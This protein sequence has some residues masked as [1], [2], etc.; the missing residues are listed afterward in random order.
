M[1]RYL[2]IHAHFYQPPRENPWLEAVELQE[3]AY[4]YHDWNER[5]TAECYA[6]NAASRILTGD[7][8]ITRIVNNYSRIS[9]NFGPTLL[10]WMADHSPDVYEAIL[11]ADRESRERFSQHGSALAQVYNHM[12]LPLANRRDKETQVIWGLRDF[13]YRFG[14]APEGM[15]LAETAVDVE[16]LEVLAANGI[17]FTV[18]AP[19]QARHERRIA[20]TK[21]KNVEGGNIDPTRAY[22][23]PLPSGR[24]INL[25]FYDG[26]ISRAV[27]F[28]GLLS[29][30]FRFANRLLSGFADHRRFPQLMHIATD[31]ETYGHHHPKG[32][33]ALSYALHH[34]ESGNLAKLTNYGEFLE[35]V[36]PTH[37]VEIID[38]TA[39]SCVHGLGRWTRDCGCNSG[40]KP[41]WNQAWR[42]PLRTALDQLRDSLAAPYEKMAA[43]LLRDPWKARDEYIDVVLNRGQRTLKSFLDQHALHELTDE[44]IVTALSL[45]E[46]QRHAMLMY[47]SC[48]WFFD[49]LSGIETVQV[50]MYAGRA[51]QLAQALFPGNYEEAFRQNLAEAKS[52]LPDH[53]DGARVYD[54][55]VKPAQVDLLA[56]AAHYA[57]ASLFR[58]ESEPSMISSYEIT[59]RDDVRMESGRARL[60]VGT[61][62]IRS[63]ITRQQTEVS[64]GVLH[65]GDHN[66]SA[67]VRA[68]Q[69]EPDFR[70]RVRE[71]RDA[72]NAADLPG[73]LR[74]LDSQFAGATYSLKS[75]FRDERNRVVR[76]I[77]GKTM[78]EAEA[79]YR[80]IYEH[81]APLMGFLSGMGAPLPKMLHQT[82]EFVLNTA[83]RSEFL[84]DQL[85]LERIQ[86]LLDTGA[87]EKVQW[88]TPWLVFALNR[89]LGKMAEELA[90]NPR[91]ERLQQFNASVALVKSLPFEVDLGRVQNVYY[92][93]LQQVY[94]LVALEADEPSQRW[95]A[96]F[97]SLG[98]KLGVCVE[99]VTTPAIQPS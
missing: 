90:V 51:L 83:L 99:P 43:K 30:G 66:V 84:A 26:P 61:A 52:N 59:Q 70:Q 81:H 1:D 67:G 21:W 15:W 69:G 63:R 65:L 3:S 62:L 48:G 18:L 23:C 27:A 19:S 20:Q 57:I 89:R 6:P 10:S 76:K 91:E 11:T 33:M 44:E 87:R 4:P 46:M 9:F 56:V 93:L 32:E 94:P 29:D 14:R 88:D 22:V 5:I 7:N 58:R 85:D 8:R 86:T 12:I 40:G 75:L 64:Y 25:F 50:I 17:N 82:A 13:E 78:T 37:E 39:W 34:I 24:S 45:L 92:Q 2:C 54:R 38:D 49:E 16:T 36:P 28:E 35:K 97:T 77:L 74:L 98:D 95:I 31:G 72:F 41:G 55:M 68:L 47:T 96:E 80:Q 53:V 71:L 73:V 42:D 79:A 60:A